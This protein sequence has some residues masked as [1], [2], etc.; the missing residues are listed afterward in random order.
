MQSLPTD[1]SVASNRDAGR[2]V[3]RYLGDAMSRHA[4]AIVLI[5]ALMASRRAA[6]AFGIAS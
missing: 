4:D 1:I 2:V 5:T 3:R 6:F